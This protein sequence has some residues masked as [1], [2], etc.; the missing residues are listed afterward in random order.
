MLHAADLDQYGLHN[1]PAVVHV[2]ESSGLSRDQIRAAE[3]E[4]DVE[5]WVRNSVDGVGRLIAAAEDGKVP[6]VEAAIEALQHLEGELLEPRG[7]LQE[8]LDDLE[9]IRERAL[10]GPL[11]IRGSVLADVTRLSGKLETISQ[12]IGTVLRSYRDGR[13]NLMTIQADREPA[14]DAPAFEDADSL[15][16]FLKA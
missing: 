16:A 8:T 9:K 13:W 6:D 12:A 1:P 4:F 11:G 7:Q 10:R 15:L 3:K 2:A 5:Q 14:G